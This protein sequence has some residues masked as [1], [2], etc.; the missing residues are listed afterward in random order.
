MVGIGICINRCRESKFEFALVV[1]I[2]VSV[3]P[4]RAKRGG[5]GSPDS[6]Y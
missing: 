6:A 1:G 4:D 3:L 5:R 2:G